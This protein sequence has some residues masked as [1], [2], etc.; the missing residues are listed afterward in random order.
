MTKVASQTGTEGGGESQGGD[1]SGAQG[2]EG[3]Q[4]QQTGQQ[5]DQGQQQQSTGQ[6]QS[7]SQQT[8]DEGKSAKV[9]LKKLTPEQLEEVLSNDGIFNTPRLKE[10]VQA[11]RELKKL[12]DEQAKRDEEA[13]V[14]Q[15]KFKELAEKRGGE[16]ETLRKQLQDTVVNQAFTNKLVNEK[17]VDLDGALKL[18]DRANVKVDE[19]GNVSG[20]DEAI[21]ALKSGKSYLFEKS[22]EESNNN[23]G[24]QTTTVGTASNT[25]NG[26]SQ[27]GKMSFKRSEIAAMTPEEYQTNRDAILR[28]QRE[29][30]IEMD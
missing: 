14:E 28:A 17:V 15:N 23:G 11:N 21:E 26:N 2:N 3:G 24:G 7:Q 8:G 6:Q 25:Q 16:V 12:K 10:L 22:G 20:V 4:Q 5:G 1:Q 13:L 18:I 30:R 27:G 9:D 29:G 19:N